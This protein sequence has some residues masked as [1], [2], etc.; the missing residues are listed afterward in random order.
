MN[1]K[2]VRYI[3]I[4]LA[5]MLIFEVIGVNFAE[6]A[7]NQNKSKDKPSNYNIEIYTDEFGEKKDI[8]WTD[9]INAPSMDGMDKG[10]GVF[11]KVEENINGVKYVEHV[12]P[13]VAGKGWY[14]INKSKGQE[15]DKNLCFSAAASNLLH[16]WFDQNEEY[17]RKYIKLN[18]GANKIDKIKDIQSSIALQ[19]NSKIYSDFVKQF[20]N[21]EKG[22]WPDI[23]QDQFINGYRPK[24][25]GGVTD[26]DFE[27][28]DLI[29]DGP[30]SN[31]GYFYSIFGTNIL[32]ERR[33]YDY[34]GSYNSLSSDLKNFINEGKATTITFDM[35]RSAHVVTLWGAEYDKNG[36]LCAVYF[37]D[38][39]DA[40]ENGMHRY[41]VINKNGTPILTTDTRTNGGGSKITCITTLKTGKDIWNN[42]LGDNKKELKINWGN[43]NFI[44]NGKLQ[45]PHV[46][47]SNIDEG[48]DI[49]VEVDGAARD[50]GTYKATVKISGTSAYKYIL[51]DNVT[52][53]FTINK[54][55]PIFLNGIRTFLNNKET[56]EF[57]KGD[58]LTGRV[59]LGMM[60][61]SSVINLTNGIIKIYSK[62]KKI[63]ESKKSDED[64]N[65]VFNLVVDDSFDIGVNTLTARITDDKNLKDYEENFEI[66]IKNTIP[67][68][69]IKPPVFKDKNATIKTSTE[70]SD[71]DN[72][73]VK[74]ACS[75]NTYGYFVLYDEN[76]NNSR[77]LKRDI[78][79]NKN[80]KYSVYLNLENIKDITYNSNT[81][82]LIVL[83][84]KDSRNVIS[85][86]NPSTLIVEK[87]II[88]SKNIEFEFI[89]Y[90]KLNKEYIVKGQN[91]YEALDENFI[92]KRNINISKTFGRS[93]A[94]EVR[95]NYI[96]DMSKNI[97]AIYDTNGKYLYK[98]NLPKEYTANNLFF[99]KDILYS[100]FNKSSITSY[101]KTYYKTKTVYK[102]KKVKWKKVKGKWKYKK[103][104]VYKTKKV[105]WKKVRGKWKYKTK[106][107][108]KSKKVKW[109][110]VY[111]KWKYK[112]KKYKIKETK[113]IKV[114]YKKKYTKV[115]NKNYLYQLNLV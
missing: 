93:I 104:Y 89:G 50:V 72:N 103:K 35:G 30:V 90:D 52:K 69:P 24:E 10:S 100:S 110:K 61:N 13:Y 40:Y 2:K 37:S 88:L 25:N 54:A 28:P 60:G 43:L 4:L 75:D 106:Y 78:S 12:A 48:D 86:I 111:G 95:D 36:N 98:I 32:T 65:Y 42:S 9:S 56:V 49:R 19:N 83:S 47:V 109:K 97:I 8:Y 112:T 68:E 26:P 66:T 46:Q 34:Q 59:A 74:A 67:Q 71:I 57:R 51:P 55:N 108:Y 85:V 23:L 58:I 29:K 7:N 81:E 6:A 14:D 92:L 70:L 44:Y 38:S 63:A 5:I 33:Y 107:I 17:I 113:K 41:K 62:N 20:A 45:K 76:N 3:S 96:Y 79:N 18:P 16:W 105:K 1:V 101:Y 31:G 53:S 21:R 114:P 80:D 99:V 64:G 22:Y 73:N 91:E 39:D 102:T 87:S 27:G 94:I 77:I 11:K 115:L 15:L 82:K 84:Y